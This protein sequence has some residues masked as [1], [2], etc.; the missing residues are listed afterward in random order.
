MRNITLCLLIALTFQ[1]NLQVSVAQQVQF[2]RD[3]RP[4][5]SSNCFHCH[6]PD[7]K[8][9]EAGLR[10]DEAKSALSPR[11]GVVAFKPGNL[12]D[13]AAWQR[14][15][16]EDDDLRMPPAHSK[17][18]L[19][20]QDRDVLRRWIEQGAQVA[21]SLGLLAAAAASIASR[22]TRLGGERH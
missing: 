1:S 5:L 17:K 7:P 14:I 16:S 12:K 4:I 19:T 2:N 10:L 6:G 15:I 22:Q 11:D 13:S 9:R 18:E 21:G 20:A 8:N 3:V